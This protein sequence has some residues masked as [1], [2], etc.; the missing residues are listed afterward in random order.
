MSENIKNTVCTVCGA[1]LS[2]DGVCSVC[3]HREETSA[4]EDIVKNEEVASSENVM[5]NEE[6]APSEDIEKSEETAPSEDIEKSEET[7]PSEDTE[8]REETAPSEVTE[9]REEPAPSE[10]TENSEET[11][12]SEDIEKREEPSASENTEKEEIAINA[13]EEK[14]QKK[15]PTDD[16]SLLGNVNVVNAPRTFGQKIVNLFSNR[17]L[18]RVVVLVLSLAMLAFVFTPFVSYKV[19]VGEGVRY[20]VSFSPKDSVELA[21]NYALIFISNLQ[22]QPI[23]GL[24]EPLNLDQAAAKQSFMS[25]AMIRQTG[26]RVTVIVAAITTVIYALLCV[27]SAL[28]ALKA[29]ISELITRKKGISRRKRH[30]ADGMICMI[31]CLMPLMI[32]CFLQAFD[33]GMTILSEFGCRGLGTKM[34]WGAILTTAVAILGSIVVC[35]ASF[36]KLTEDEEKPFTKLRITRMVC[37]VLMILLVV[38][39]FL[40]C[41]TVSIWHENGETDTYFVDITDIKEMPVSDLKNYRTVARQYGATVIDNLESGQVGSIQTDDVGKTLFHTVMICRIDPRIIYGAVI[42]VTMITLLFVGFLLWSTVRHCFFETPKFGSMK[43]LKVFSTMS[44]AAYLVMVIV[45]N[46]VIQFCLL[47]DLSYML[48]F[49][50]GIGTIIAAVIMVAILIIRQKS[51]KKVVNRN[52]DYDNADVSYAPYVLGK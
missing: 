7:A 51:V 9:K 4:S 28:L 30:A 41:S 46:I 14:E 6:V 48:G 39:I 37:C 52:T 47:L 49:S 8:N 13:T 33:F 19:E 17:I 11:A 38:S 42:A 32:F 31:A 12:P 25:V 18:V 36:F 45:M 23:P 26:L 50:I 35:A 43:A 34:A 10:D 21:A 40:P 3:G 44:I 1:A 2:D 22:H 24:S 16:F 29:L 27:I 5:K 15:H 20:D